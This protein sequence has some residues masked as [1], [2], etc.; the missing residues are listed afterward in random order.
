M[1][2]QYIELRTEKGCAEIILPVMKADKERGTI[3][4]A[5]QAT[6]D[7]TMQLANLNI[8]N[9]IFEI[10]GPYGKQLKIENYGSV[11]SIGRGQGIAFLYPI[12]ASLRAAG[13]RIFTV[14]SARTKNQIVFEPE[15]RAISDEVIIMTDD[16]S[17]GEKDP[18][19]HLAGKAI[20][21][22]RFD[23]VY[24]IGCAKTVK[25]TFA[26]AQKYNIPTQAILYLGKSGEQKLNGI[27]NVNI[28]GS[29]KSVCVDGLNFN[30]YYSNFEEMTKRFG[31]E[32]LESVCTSD[33]SNKVNLPV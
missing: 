13:N 30:A 31:N 7:S 9:E 8:G 33:V 12:L 22:N 1:P 27:F 5:V 21:N 4:L 6:N 16:G 28:C 24:T 26:M 10:T 29:A 19:C 25:E 23:Q 32:Y 14:L 18:L 2:G 3:T 11:L 20:R 17:Y 15:I